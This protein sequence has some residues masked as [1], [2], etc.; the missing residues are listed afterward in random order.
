MAVRSVSPRILLVEDEPLIRFA[1]AEALRELGVSV[2]E[3]ASADEAWHYLTGGGAADLVFTDHRMPGS[4]TG[5]QL[6][7]WIRRRYPLLGVIVTSGYF[8]DRE[9]QE[10]ILPKPYDLLKTAAALAE[11][12]IGDGKQKEENS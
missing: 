5:S 10:P 3:V 7:A 4:M 2:V 1:L 6:A 12:A 8:N 9:W 11:L